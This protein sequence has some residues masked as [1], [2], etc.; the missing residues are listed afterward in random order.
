MSDSEIQKKID[1]EAK[2]NPGG[3]PQGKLT[4]VAGD[5]GT[6]TPDGLMFRLLKT[7]AKEAGFKVDVRDD[8]GI[9]TDGTPIKVFSFDLGS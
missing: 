7:R 5:E 4:R 1:Q 8:E 3:I 6:A 2:D 9:C